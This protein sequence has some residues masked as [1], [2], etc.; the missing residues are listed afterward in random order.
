MVS[1]FFACF[2]VL[3]G[4]MDHQAYQ[5]GWIQVAIDNDIQQSDYYSLYITAFYWTVATFTSVGYGDIKG[6]TEYEYTFQLL[7]ELTG[8]G[9][10]GYITGS[11]QEVLVGLSQDDVV[12][13]QSS[14]I[15]HWLMGLDK[16]L[17]KEI[18]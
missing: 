7:V 10:F 4:Q 13:H 3:I 11:L 17:R 18:P 5:E 9:F 15:D 8:M 16:A 2:W 14:E 1:H 12:T 6:N